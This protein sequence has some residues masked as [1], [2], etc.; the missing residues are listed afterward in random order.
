MSNIK[1]KRELTKEEKALCQ[2]NKIEFD[3]YDELKDGFR[4]REINNE[5]FITRLDLIEL[6]LGT[7]L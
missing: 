2:E 5:G 7:P 1:G 4:R 3:T 6:L